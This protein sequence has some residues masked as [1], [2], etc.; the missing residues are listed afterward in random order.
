MSDKQRE[1]Q[2]YRTLKQKYVGLGDENT[3]KDEWLTNVQRDTYNSLQGHAAL[4]EYITLGQEDRVRTKAGMRVELIKKMASI[5]DTN[6]ELRFN[7]DES[8]N[9]DEPANKKSKS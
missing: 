3:T 1:Q 9:D 7:N 5:V 6:D 4:L 8:G 2:Q